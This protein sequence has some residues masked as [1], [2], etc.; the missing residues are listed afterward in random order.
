MSLKPQD[1]VIVLRLVTLGE[2]RWS[3]PSLA[4]DLFMSPSG[5]HAG[6]KRSVESGLLEPRKRRPRIKAIE[7]FLVHG[8]KYVFPPRRGSLTRGMPTRYAARP[9][10]AEI[11]QSTV[12][13]PVWPYAQG[14]VRGYVFSPLYETVPMAA[15]KDLRLYELLALVDAIRGGR[16]R[17]TSIAIE[18]LKERLERKPYRR[19]GLQ[20]IK[21]SDLRQ[22]P[23]MLESGS[24]L[25][26]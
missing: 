13:P 25:L 1:I 11:V 24:G 19:R 17:E 8:I 22:S 6:V 3:Y 23:P 10:K 20:G 15:E 9:L 21:T 26:K 16:A 2:R 4:D 14:A 7:E 12:H 18:A 5:V